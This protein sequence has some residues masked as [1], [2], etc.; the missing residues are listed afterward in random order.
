ML[1]LAVMGIA[2]VCVFVIVRIL[3]IGCL[4]TQRS[5]LREEY[6]YELSSSDR[7]SSKMLLLPIH[8]KVSS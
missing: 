5:R 8:S 2:S 3:I 1:H 6:E 4:T 7:E